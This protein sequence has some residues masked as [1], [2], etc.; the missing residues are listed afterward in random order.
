M[1]TA[2]AHGMA[3]MNDAMLELVRKGLVDAD[4]ALAKAPNRAELRTLL[5]RAGGRPATARE[6]ASVS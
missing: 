6:T 1:Q 2:R 4:E 5:E 3:T